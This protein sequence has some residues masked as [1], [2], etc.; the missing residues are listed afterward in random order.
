VIVDDVDKFEQLN[1]E[2]GK[3]DKMKRYIIEILSG[4]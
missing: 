2:I 3:S 4:R 1:G